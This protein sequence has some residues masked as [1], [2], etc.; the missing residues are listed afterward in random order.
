MSNNSVQK[1]LDMLV[2]LVRS[3]PFLKI[4]DRLIYAQLVSFRLGKFSIP[5]Q[6]IEKYF[7]N[8]ITN[9]QD[10]PSISVYRDSKNPYVCHFSSNINTKITKK[11]IKLYVPLDSEHIKDGVIELFSFLTDESIEHDSKVQSSIRND[12]II[13]RLSKIEDVNKIIKYIKN[14]GNLSQGLLNANPFLV[15][16][17]KLGVIIDNHYTYNIEITKVLAIILNELR[18][19]N[20]LEKFNCVYIKNAFAKKCIKC[21]DEELSELYKLASLALDENNSLQ[22]FANYVIEYQ[23]TSYINRHGS[24]KISYNDSVDYFNTAVLET[25]KR[26]N[27]LSYLINAVKLYLINDNVK[28]FTRVNSARK[29]LTLY[30]DRDHLK[31]LFDFENLDFSIKFYLLKV[32]TKDM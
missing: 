24:D 4:T 25:F 2:E 12:N 8:W 10:N 21:E 15:P 31:S 32:I 29:N 16:C 14:N 17:F 30:A 3:N 19:K 22:D 7:R 11:I 27:N 5:F 20:E 1:F 23:Q 13:I 28:G 6:N 9:F 18:E 26:Y